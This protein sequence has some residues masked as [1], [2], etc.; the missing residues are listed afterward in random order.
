[1]Y[2]KQSRLGKAHGLSMKFFQADLIVSASL[3][4]TLWMKLCHFRS[5]HYFKGILLL[6]TLRLQTHHRYFFVECEVQ[7]NNCSLLF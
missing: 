6:L 3:S 2:R 1:M 7:T 4:Q 5:F